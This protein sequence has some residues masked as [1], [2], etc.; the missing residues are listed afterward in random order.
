MANMNGG[1]I[2]TKQLKIEGV[3]VIFN[4]PGDPMTEINT[5]ARQEGVRLINFRHEQACALA[6]QAYGYITRQTWPVRGIRG[7]LSRL[8]FCGDIQTVWVRN[9]LKSRDAKQASR[10]LRVHMDE[11]RS[12]AQGIYNALS[13]SILEGMHRGEEPASRRIIRLPLLRKRLAH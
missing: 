3:D 6:A 12:K 2:L 5:A 7:W 10:L 4:M 13:E 11:Y 9:G 1:E 8:G